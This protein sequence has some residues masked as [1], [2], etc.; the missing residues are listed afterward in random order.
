MSVETVVNKN[1]FLYLWEIMAQEH[2]R[3]FS[4]IFRPLPLSHAGATPGS[5]W[6]TS[7]AELQPFVQDALTQLSP[8]D[9]AILYLREVEKLSCMEITGRIVCSLWGQFANGKA[10][11]PPSGGG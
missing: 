3:L 10:R 11:P 5:Q 7:H 6:Q 2:S 1:D 9:L 4:P 8:A